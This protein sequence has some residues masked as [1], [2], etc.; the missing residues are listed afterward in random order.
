MDLQEP[1]YVKFRNYWDRFPDG[2]PPGHYGYDPEDFVP[3]CDIQSDEKV[4]EVGMGAGR[5]CKLM[6]LKTSQCFFVDFHWAA[7]ISQKKTSKNLN[8]INADGIRLPFKSETFDK[9]L[10]R[11]VIHNFPGADFRTSFYKETF[12][13]L[14]Y[15][16]EMI[17]GMV[18]NK[19]GM[20]C[21]LRNYIEPRFWHRLRKKNPTWYALS[22][23]KMKEELRNLGFEYVH[24]RKTP[25]ATTLEGN[26]YRRFRRLARRFFLPVLF[27][28][29][30]IYNYVDLRFKKVK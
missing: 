10:A 2:F 6:T 21:D 16:G 11:Y 28:S 25:E 17:L 19:V 20:R 29:P 7:V 18:P 24:M 1:K 30:I 27:K 8:V 26:C 13:I 22:I 15:D 5:T 3:F 12:R 4:L 23:K 14:K 9:V